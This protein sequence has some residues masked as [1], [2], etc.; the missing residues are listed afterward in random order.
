MH[1]P[2]LANPAVRVSRAD[3]PLERGP[4]G[5]LLSVPT[6]GDGVCDINLGELPGGDLG[7]RVQ[8]WQMEEERAL[9]VYY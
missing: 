2:A 6:L 9:D 5:L 3:V 4:L 8:S 7:G 1:V